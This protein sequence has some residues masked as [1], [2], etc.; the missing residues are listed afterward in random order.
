MAMIF[1]KKNRTS[2][3]LFLRVHI[4]PLLVLRHF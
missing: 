4:P 3:S 1:F 2:S